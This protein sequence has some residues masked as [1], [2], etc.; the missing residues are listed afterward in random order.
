MYAL[1]G[2]SGGHPAPGMGGATT[3]NIVSIHANTSSKKSFTLGPKLT[4]PPG[5]SGEVLLP[6]RALPVPFWAKGFLPP[7]RTSVRVSVLAVPCGA[8]PD[9]IRQASFTTMQF[10]DICT[11]S[12]APLPL[13]NSA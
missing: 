5:K 4:P 6:R 3:T 7:P 8:K 10:W 9:A 12:G 1:D 2:G 11:S 13:M